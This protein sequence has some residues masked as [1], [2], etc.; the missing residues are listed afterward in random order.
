MREP[1]GQEWDVILQMPTR[2]K[3]SDKYA[4]MLPATRDMLRAFY[5]PF[6]KKLAQ[7]LNDERYL[8]NDHLQA[9]A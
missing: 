7:L 3:Q 9:A 5:E 2:N 1:V 6:N 4:K 8:W